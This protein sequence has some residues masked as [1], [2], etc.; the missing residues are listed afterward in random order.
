MC[1]LSLMINYNRL[2][3]LS[4]L[5]RLSPGE[6]SFCLKL[7]IK[8]YPGP[9]RYVETICLSLTAF[10]LMLPAVT[11]ILTR[12]PNGNPLV[13]DLNSPI[14]LGSQATL[15]VLLIVGLTAQIILLRRQSKLE[16][17]DSSTEMSA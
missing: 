11:E 7:P 14:L 16:A 8:E 5:F 9:G 13:T 1:L 2:F 15:L 10:L 4:S 12:V 6:V 3:I 17:F